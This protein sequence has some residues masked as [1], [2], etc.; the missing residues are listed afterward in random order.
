KS[1][2]SEN[3][4]FIFTGLFDHEETVLNKL[5]HDWKTNRDENKLLTELFQILQSV[6]HNSKGEESLYSVLAVQHSYLIPNKLPTVIKKIIT[7]PP[8]A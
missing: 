6:F 3:G 2:S 8:Q 7:P 1:Y 5:Q 4:K